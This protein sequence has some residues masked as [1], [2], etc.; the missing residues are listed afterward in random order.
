MKQSL[1]LFQLTLLIFSMSACGHK[2][3][4]GVE[5][6]KSYSPASLQLFNEIAQMDSIMFSAF[7]EHNTEKLMSFFTSDVEFYHDKGGLS[8]FEQTTKGFANMFAQNASTGLR[9]DLV[10]GSLEVYPIN[11]Y[12]AVETCLHRFCHVENGKDDCGTFK[13]IMVWKMLDT[14][15]KVSRVI[16]YDH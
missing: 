16:S 5:G 11:N 7:N 15:W 6:K 9:R 14:G 3:I 2:T 8:N 4:S 1:H 12:G 10:S 13:N